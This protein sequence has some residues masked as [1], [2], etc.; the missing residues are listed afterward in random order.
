MLTGKQVA[1]IKNIKEN[2]DIGDIDFKVCFS[3]E[4]S[5]PVYSI[6]VFAKNYDCIYSKTSKADVLGVKFVDNVIDE[7]K[8]IFRQV[9]TNG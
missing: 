1:D 9:K 4:G 8:S 7:L 2:L 3:D 5:S 6:N